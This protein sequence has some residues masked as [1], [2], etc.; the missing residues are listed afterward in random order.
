MD[1]GLCGGLVHNE[2]HFRPG[3]EEQGRPGFPLR[4]HR[5]GH[6]ARRQA[7]P[8]VLL[9]LGIL[10]E[11]PARN[12]PAHPGAG[13]QLPVRA[14][15]WIRIYRFY[16][17]CLPRGGRRCYPRNVLFYP[18]AQGVQH[19]VPPGPPGHP[20]FAWGFFGAAREFFQFRDQR[21]D[22]RCLLR[23]CHALC[24]GFR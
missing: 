1:C 9:R 4:I 14:Y 2:A 13:G 15:Q 7:R 20:I 8:C 5:P 16:G 6:H 21:E 24:Q 3:R 23:F 17:A 11:P 22:H 10:P 12:P 18:E 19:P